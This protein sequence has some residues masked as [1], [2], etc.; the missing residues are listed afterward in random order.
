MS[1]FLRLGPSRVRLLSLGLSASAIG[2]GCS[3]RAPNPET[4]VVET[5]A[6]TTS[7]RAVIPF[8]T[9][10]STFCHPPAVVRHPGDVNGDGKS[11]I[12]LTGGFVPC[13]NSAP[14]STLPVA[15]SNGD[16]NFT[17][18]NAVITNFATYATQAG[19]RPV[20]GDFDGDGRWDVAL[21]GAPGWSTVPVAFSNGDGSFR[22]TNSGVQGFPTYAQQT[23]FQPVV[24]DFDGDGR[25]DIALIGGSNWISIPVAF[26]NGDGT[27]R[28]LNM[29]T[30]DAATFNTFA[31]QNG[32]L[33]AGDFN[34]D[35]ELAS[36]RVL[37]WRWD[38]SGR[39]HSE[40][41]RAV[42][43]VRDSARVRAGGRLRR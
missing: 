17:T 29:P 4:T 41:R 10:G 16:G 13:T 24:G 21:T 35:L 39:E 11:D 38:I 40:R 15:F 32:Q 3:S 9:T 2:F 7:V 28:V 23:G 19:A 27:F 37:E 14:W 43:D 12:A 42:P 36:R 33:V 34:G 30:A 18:T 6:L 22:V 8:C 20:M 25:W 1:P 26:S 31:R 5:S